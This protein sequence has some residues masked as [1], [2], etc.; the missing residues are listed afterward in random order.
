MN[1]ESYQSE[2][3][4]W[5]E[6]RARRLAEPDGWLAAAGLF[7]L[8]P[9]ENR[10]GDDPRNPIPLPAGSAPAQAGVFTLTGEKIILQAKPGV[11]ILIGD[12]PVSTRNIPLGEIEELDWIQINGLKLQ[13]LQRGERV[14]VRVFDPN[15]PRRAYFQGLRWFPIQEAYRVP[16]RFTPAVEPQT[17]SILNLLGDTLELPCPGVV[18]FSLNGENCRLH[19]LEAE[20]GRL[21]FIFRDAT[22]GELTYPAGRY[23]TADPPQEGQAIL[24]FNKA[25]NPPCAYTEH[26]TCPLPPA[27][28]RLSVAITAG[29]LNYMME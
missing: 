27:S 10:L 7:W 24:D 18:E 9:G 11:E 8:T 1:D 5:R 14:G 12:Q 28:N 23:L 17:L 21:W 13:L 6:A 4:K 26:A 19:P 25:T 20:G 29:E 22:S 16:A 15:H 2:I 3:I